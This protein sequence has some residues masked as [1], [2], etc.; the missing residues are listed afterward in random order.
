LLKAA[1][2]EAVDLLLTT[3]RRLHYQQNVNGRKIGIIVLTGST[4]W[5]RVRLHITRIAA[6]VDSFTPGSYLEIIIPLDRL[7]A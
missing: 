5:S 2:E 3:D 1:Q 4:K 7:S 6:A